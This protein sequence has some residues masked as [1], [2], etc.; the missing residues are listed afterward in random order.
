M[1]GK[2]CEII[3]DIPPGTQLQIGYPVLEDGSFV[4]ITRDLGGGFFYVLSEGGQ[5]M[6]STEY[7]AICQALTG[8]ENL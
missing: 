8:S 6:V 3:R 4:L 1:I 5:A 7:L 2:I